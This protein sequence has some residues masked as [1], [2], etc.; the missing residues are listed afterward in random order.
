MVR[1]YFDLNASFEVH[2]LSR[3][4]D[5]RG[6]ELR[7]LVAGVAVG[8][9]LLGADGRV[10]AGVEEEDDALAAVLGQRERALRPLEGEIRRGVS[11]VEA[12]DQTYDPAML[13][14]ARRPTDPIVVS[15]SSWIEL[16]TTGL[17]V[18]FVI[19]PLLVLVHEMGHAFAA[20]R[21]GRRP[22]VIVGKTPP[23]FEARLP[24]LDLSFHFLLGSARRR[25][26]A[27]GGC[28][29]DRAGLTVSELRGV[30]SAGPMASIAAGVCLA[31]VALL[32]DVP[33]VRVIALSGAILGWLHGISNLIPRRSSGFPTDGYTMSRYRHLD[34]DLVLETPGPKVIGESERKATRA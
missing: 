11:D 28:C 16:V 5:E 26:R 12:H 17:V 27:P 13:K 14:S 32:V 29:Y 30:A 34:P 8:A 4:A 6:V 10:V 9:E 31:L 25:I 2:V 1:P 20:I 18:V 3:D 23:L 22:D 7:H 33:A 19:N 15:T 24:R 21:L